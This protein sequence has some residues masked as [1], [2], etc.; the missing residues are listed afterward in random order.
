VNETIEEKDDNE[1]T[2]FLTEFEK[3]LPLRYI[4]LVEF[5]RRVKKL[6]TP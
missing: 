3:K 5:E 4:S 2:A 6:A 1:S